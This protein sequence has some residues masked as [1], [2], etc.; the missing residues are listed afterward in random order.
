MNAYRYKESGLDNV[1]IEGG[2]LVEDDAGEECVTIPNINGLHQAIAHGIVI[3]QSAITGPELRFLRT[4]MG[5]TQAQLAAIVHREPLAVSRWERNEIEIDSNAEA[6]IRLGAIEALN[7]PESGVRE[8]A[9]WCVPS[10]ET[11]PIRIDGSDPTNYKIA[12]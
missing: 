12:A 8:I 10:A 7:L 5:M 3:K 11:A 4:E 1:Y 6:I 2:N 9:G